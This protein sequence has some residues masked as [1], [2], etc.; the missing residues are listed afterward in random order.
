MN[1]LPRAVNCVSICDQYFVSDGTI[2]AHGLEDTWRRVLPF[3]DTFGISRVADVTELDTLGLPVSMCIRPSAKNLTSCQ[4]K[5]LS[6]LAARVSA[7]MESIERWHA[8]N[9]HLPIFLDSYKSLQSSTTYAA[10]VDPKI[11]FNERF[12]RSIHDEQKIRWCEGRNLLDDQAFLIPYD[13]INLD[14]FDVSPYSV[15]FNSSANGLASGNTRDEATLHAIFELIERHNFYYWS[16]LS[17]VEKSHT[18]VTLANFPGL[19]LL[20]SDDIKVRVWNISSNINIPTFQCAIYSEDPM[21]QLP[22]CLGRGCH[23]FD[24][25]AI[26]RAITE[27]AQ[28]RLTLI[29]GSRDDMS[30]S[31][32]SYSSDNYLLF[33]QRIVI[34]YKQVSNISIDF[35][36]MK[37][38]VLSVLSK[39]GF[40][41]I[42]C[43]DHTH[44]V[45][46]IPVIRVVIPE[47]RCPDQR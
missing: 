5:G 16:Q 12:L 26:Y 2:R 27:A 20:D 36:E 25:I 7:V 13:Y 41:K 14:T 33:P 30:A 8:E 35:E 28:S 6:Q 11:F 31:L 40:N 29:A 24:T 34:N 19:P 3:F 17:P 44:S 21:R 32:Y 23:E 45:F 39:Q 15:L 47:M 10:A 42:I 1:Q 9:L 46:D 38:R 22:V 18:E 37:R 4:G 43:L